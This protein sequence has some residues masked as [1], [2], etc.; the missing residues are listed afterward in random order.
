MESNVYK[1]KQPKRKLAIDLRRKVVYSVPIL[2]VTPYAKANLSTKEEEARDNAR[3]SR[4][5]AVEDRYE[6]A[7]EAPTEGPSEARRIGRRLC[8]LEKND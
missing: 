1:E 4:P 8:S 7:R 6:G 3:L 2:V 5:L